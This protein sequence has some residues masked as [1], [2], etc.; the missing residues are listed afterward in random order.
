LY[1][2]LSRDG[3]IAEYEKVKRAYKSAGLPR[4]HPRD[5]VSIDVEVEPVL[6]LTNKR[7]RQACGVSLAMITGDSQESLETC[8][9]VADLARARAYRAVLSPSAALRDAKNLNIYLEGMA[10]QL[11]IRKGKYRMRLP[12]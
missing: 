9:Q 1:T 6:D 11:R 8:R 2:A 10:A 12:D 3:A 4:S 5:L 7:I